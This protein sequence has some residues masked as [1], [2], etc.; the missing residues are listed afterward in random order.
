MSMLLDIDLEPGVLHVVATGEFSLEEG[1]RTF[2]QMLA[3]VAVHK[4][5]KV[6]FDGSKLT[7]NP[8]TLE[9]FYYGEFAAQ[10]VVEFEGRGVSCDTQFAYILTEPLLDPKRFG[11][12]VAVNRGMKVKAF[13]NAAEALQWLVSVYLLAINCFSQV[14]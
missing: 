6:L 11:E 8:E 1:K 12:T 5:N 9:R 10:S 13:D 4:S 2:L 3:A 7:G 14:G